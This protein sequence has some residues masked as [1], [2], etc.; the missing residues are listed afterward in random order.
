MASHY[1]AIKS[2]RRPDTTCLTTAVYIA[3]DN[4]KTL[5]SSLQFFQAQ[6][7]GHP[8]AL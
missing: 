5:Y 1:K 4:V 6:F 3:S 7:A 2:I 8:S